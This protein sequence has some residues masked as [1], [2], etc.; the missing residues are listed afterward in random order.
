MV[1]RLSV[2]FAFK[3]SYWSKGAV[4]GSAFS[5]QNLERVRKLIPTAGFPDDAPL[6][7]LADYSQLR[8]GRKVFLTQCVSCYD[9]KTILTRP[10]TPGDWVRTVERMANRQIFDATEPEQQWAVSAYLIA[11]SPE[12]Q[13]SAKARR[14]EEIRAA[15]SVA[16]VRVAMVVPVDGVGQR[17]HNVADAQ[18]LFEDTCTMCHELDEVEEYPLQSQQD[19][20]DLL[21]RMV[22]NG[23][24]VTEEDSETIAWYINRTYV[25]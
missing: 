6:A 11:I 18:A 12:L 25:D 3:E 2:P 24:E 10:R 22:G 4:G 7:D 15:E 19:I 23:L 16:A 5:A 8:G 14:V 17:E 21:Q 20:S 13:N 9:L 1:V